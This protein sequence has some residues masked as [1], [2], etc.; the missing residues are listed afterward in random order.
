MALEGTKRFCSNC[1]HVA[2]TYSLNQERFFLGKSHSQATDMPAS[3]RFEVFPADLEKRIAFY[4]N[5]LRFII[6]RKKDG[7]AYFRRDSIFIGAD[8]SHFEQGALQGADRTSRKPPTGVEVVIEVDELEA[9]RNW[10]VEKGWVLDADIKLQ[11]WG[12]RDFRITDPDGF[13]LRITEHSLR[14]QREAIGEEL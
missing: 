8:Q 5:V 7:Y 14:G 10:V 9:E 12:L 3:V 11:D 2:W 4:T 6:V 13:Y 1:M